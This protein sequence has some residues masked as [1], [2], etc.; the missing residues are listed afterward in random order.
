MVQFSGNARRV[1]QT[2]SESHD[3]G[4]DWRGNVRVCFESHQQTKEYRTLNT[5]KRREKQ[6]MPMPEKLPKTE[7]IYDAVLP[8]GG[9]ITGDFAAQVGTEIKALIRFNG[10]TILRRTIRTLRETGRIRQI[11]VIGSE[12]VAE[13]TRCCGA[14]VIALPEKPT[15]TENILSGLAYVAQTPGQKAFVVPTDLPFATPEALLAVLDAGNAQTEVLVPVVRREDFERAFPGVQS[16]YV[17]LREGEM[18]LGCAFRLDPNAILRNQAAL[19]R[20]FNARKSNMAMAKLLGVG[21]ILRYLTKTL[22]V[23]HI[24]ARCEAILGCRGAAMLNAP[25]SLAYDID[26]PED[27]EFACQHLAETRVNHR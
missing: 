13:E 19:D 3:L 5:N 20:V 15:G 24:E 14:D 7:L 21:F 23:L 26:T 11:I 22:S 27:Y 10:E 17:P 6:S 9:R 1:L 18:T 4:L 16:I 2:A 8:A 25:A 12:E